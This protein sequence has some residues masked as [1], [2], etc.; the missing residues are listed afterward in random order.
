MDRCNQLQKASDI[1]ESQLR[2]A[3]AEAHGDLE[4]LADRFRVSSRWQTQQSAA[5]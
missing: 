1:P 2:I 4:Q 3:L 5:P